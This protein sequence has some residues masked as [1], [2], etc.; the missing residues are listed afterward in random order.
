M[1]SL[2]E[3]SY[4]AYEGEHLLGEAKDFTLEHLIKL[5]LDNEDKLISE[6]VHYILELPLR[7]RLPRLEARHYIE[8]HPNW[9]DTKNIPA[10]LELAK[11]DFNMTQL[12]Y[13]EDLHEMSR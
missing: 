5:R 7:Y 6:Y 2:Y 11:I 3:A 12:T 13:Q 4:L 8:T 9:E 10:W 1:I